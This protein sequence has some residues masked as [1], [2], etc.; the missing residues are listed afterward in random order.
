MTGSSD[1]D[2]VERRLP[3]AKPES[4]GVPDKAV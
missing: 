1:A 4:D 2:R 3:A